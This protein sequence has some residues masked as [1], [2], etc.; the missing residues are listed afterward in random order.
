MIFK[1]HKVCI[2]IFLG[3]ILILL[4]Q[5]NYAQEFIRFKAAFS[6]KT[7]TADGQSQL[8]I[9]TV[10]FDKNI[11]K[12]VYQ[13]TFP[14]KDVW[15]TMDTSIFHLNGGHVIKVM[16]NVSINKLTIYYLALNGNLSDFGLSNS[17]F[18]LES[19][20]KK[21]DM[22]ISTWLAPI[23]YKKLISKILISNKQEQLYGVVILDANNK[24]VSKQFY[25]NYILANGLVFPSEIIQISYTE[26]NKEN[27][28]ITTYRDIIVNDFK[29]N[30]MYDYPVKY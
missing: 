15:I 23:E 16:P 29:E 4:P 27:Y 12:I 20:E 10:Y 19:V 21:K 17:K 1:K 8:S 7:K 2:L 25:K 26:D 28:Q 13:N 18:K 3:A 22:V 30:S 24:V 6:I 5:L 9:G 11:D 14:Q